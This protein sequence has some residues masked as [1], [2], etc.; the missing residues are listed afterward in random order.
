VARRIAHVLRESSGGLPAVRAI[1]VPLASRGLVQVAMNLLDY[2][3]T[4]VSVVT[5][6]LEDEAHRDHVEVLEYELVG[7]APRDAVPEAL[8]PRI[9][10]LRRS[11]LLDPELFA[12]RG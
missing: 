9:A 5:R 12:P 4:P 2:R 7:C 1:G 3:R 11:Q 10:G 6:R 8:A